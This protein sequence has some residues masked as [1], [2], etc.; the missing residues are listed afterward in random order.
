MAS[1][2]KEFKEKMVTRM[3][4]PNSEPVSKISKETKISVATL[5]KW[6]NN[7]SASSQPTSSRK[8]SSDKWSSQDKFF[9][10][11]ET[12]GM[13]EIELSNYSR[14]KGLYVEQIKEWKNVCMEANGGVA[15][16]ASRLNKEMKVKDKEIKSLEKELLRKDK[17]LAETAAI[18]VL[19]KKLNTL[20][21]NDDEE[22]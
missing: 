22:E 9:I 8:Q 2:S 12:A 18:L 20:L 13:N 10:V 4:P 17:A 5:H 15:E 3:L 19:R 7:F 16:E 6:K 21:G 14:S 11:M 1:Y